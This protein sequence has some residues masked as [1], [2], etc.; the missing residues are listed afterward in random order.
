MLLISQVCRHIIVNVV[1][2]YSA[3]HL[4]AFDSVPPVNLPSA[5]GEICTKAAETAW[6]LFF[7]KMGLWVNIR[8]SDCKV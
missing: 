4:K 6:G 2:D 3:I 5:Y 1:A 8:F 7:N